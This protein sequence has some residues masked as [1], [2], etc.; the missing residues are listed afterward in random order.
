MSQAFRIPE[1]PRAGNENVAS[2]I[3]NA[4]GQ[5]VGNPII[6]D[7]NTFL[8]R[9]QQGGLPLA[10]AQGFNEI[11]EAAIAG[12]AGLPG[13][14]ATGR[15]GTR[16]LAGQRGVEALGF[17][18]K[19][20]K[21]QQPQQAPGSSAFQILGD[22]SREQQQQGQRPAAPQGAQGARGLQVP[23]L[24]DLREAPP[25]DFSQAISALGGPA[26]AQQVGGNERLSRTLGG[27]AAGGLEAV[28]GAPQGRAAT[29]G[30]VL[31]GIGAGGAATSAALGAENRQLQA[32][33]DAQNFQRQRDLSN[34]RT[35][36]T[37]TEASR[38]QAATEAYN[39][40]S[41]LETQLKL[42]VDQFNV[43]QNKPIA[44]TG[45]Y[46][47]PATMEF[48]STASSLQDTFTVIEF[49]QK[50]MDE[51]AT[52]TIH[53]AVGELIINNIPEGRQLTTAAA[54]QASTD[55][56]TV[57]LAA[58]IL[59]QQ[60]METEA[61]NVLQLHE[62]ATGGMTDQQV[63]SATAALVNVLSTM[64][65][66]NWTAELNGQPPVYETLNHNMW[67]SQAK[68]NP[69]LRTSEGQRALI[70]GALGQ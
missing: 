51:A 49:A 53:T 44:V 32:S 62:G 66:E 52:Q 1:I 42:D 35:V 56:E 39:R 13:A 6:R 60:G 48:V 37:A 23:Q 26:E 29:L 7:I 11:P 40:R 67:L 2:Q 24:P 64:I 30:E 41:L 4:L 16:L 3:A 20:K 15:I 10:L 9:T 22:L 19:Q 57:R 68:A 8:Q 18:Q 54:I 61:T 63:K 14:Q 12:L 28:R 46:I 69:A 21:G 31:A 55:N 38:S 27:L 65:F 43:E 33:T 34:I 59:D 5:G 25:A 70:S 50:M 47:I 17:D 36:E 58:A 45:G